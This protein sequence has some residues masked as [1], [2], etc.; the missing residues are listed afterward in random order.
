MDGARPSPPSP[1]QAGGPGLGTLQARSKSFALESK[2]SS[3]PSQ[4]T[5]RP[6]SV[7]NTLGLGE[8]WTVDLFTLA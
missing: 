1:V 3:C 8:Q 6:V 5:T 2:S 7:P 4:P